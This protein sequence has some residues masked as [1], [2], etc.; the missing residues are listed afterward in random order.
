MEPMPTIQHI[1]LSYSH[2]DRRFAERLKSELEARGLAVWLDRT[3]MRAG[4]SIQGRIEHAIET[5]SFVL[6]ILSPHSISSTFVQ[7]E[8]RAAMA[9]Q[10]IENNRFVIPILYRQCLMPAFLLDNL[11][12]DF[13]S[14][15]NFSS[16][17]SE[18]MSSLDVIINETNIPT[19]SKP[20]LEYFFSDDAELLV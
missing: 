9:K 12:I 19:P 10:R 16:S 13:T 17:I 7:E 15:R 14:S 11:Y 18:L 8:L 5:A 2:R 20:F 6:V 3:E 1:F 4:E